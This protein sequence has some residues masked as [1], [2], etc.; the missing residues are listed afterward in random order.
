MSLDVFLPDMLGWTVLS[1][2]KQ[3]PELRH[4]PVQIVTLDDNRQHGLSRG[5]FS[6]ITK[7]ATTEGLEEAFQRIKDYAAPRRKRLLIVEDNHA[8][9]LS[10][11]ELLGHDDIDVVTASN[12]EDAL[13]ILKQQSIDCVVLDLR[14]PDIS[15]LDVLNRLHGELDLPDL[16]VVVFTGKQLS[17]EQEKELQ[18]LARKVVIKGVESPERL[19]DETA[20]F[21][22]RV[23]AE[24]PPHKQRML[25]R[26]H[27]SDED[28]QGQ[29][30][31][32]VDD[33]VHQLFRI[34]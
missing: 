11:K 22:H 30:V 27:R 8:E 21:L 28:L 10:I 13:G 9:L 31:L 25:E 4:I 19:L 5:A 29:R 3:D 26:L 16:P 12:G 34:G 7:P 23:I 15:G 6:F 17:S 24:L 1:H 14:L 18:E 20:L 32:I 33:D 2:F